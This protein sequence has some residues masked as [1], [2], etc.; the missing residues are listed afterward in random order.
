MMTPKIE[1][2][3]A[4]RRE[5]DSNPCVVVDLDVIAEKYREISEQM[6]LVRVFYAVK[7]NPAPEIL[8]MLVELGSCFDTASLQEIEMVLAA[9]ASPDRISFGN[10]IKKERDIAR[11]YQLGVR[12]FAFDSACELQKIA[13]S[14]PGSKVFCRIL[15]DCQA[16]DW[17]LSKKF[18]CAPEMALELLTDAASA[19]LDAYGISFHVGSQQTDPEQ[20]D[21]AISQAAAIFRDL[22]ERGVSA[23]MV[24]LGGGLPAR[25]QDEVAPMAAYALAISQ[26][27]TRH[28]GNQL[29]EMIIEPGRGLVGDA[30]VLEAE[31]ILIAEK[32]FDDPVRWVY[33][34]V[35]K[36]NGLAE[37]MDE[38]IKYRL[39]TERDGSETGRVILAGPT[40]DSVDVLYE[41]AGYE[42]PHAL[43]VGDKIT[44]LSCGAY[45]TTYA[46]TG[47]NGFPPIQAYYI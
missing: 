9:G 13:R 6:P 26:A 11:A 40:C 5:Y 7:A 34:D 10:T 8:S 47:F 33:L 29:P 36:F 46:T 2:F 19:G 23:R 4:G 41:K 30:G 27:M 12:L 16:A 45:T 15:V 35:G 14:A 25:Y 39:R 32:S 3:L 38:A 31:V 24:N 21:R 37:T 44:F 43:Q 20:W 28:F 42:L 1:R 22:G 17:P 18:G